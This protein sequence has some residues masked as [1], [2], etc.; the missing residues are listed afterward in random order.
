M[1]SAFRYFLGFC[2]LGTHPFG[3]RHVGSEHLDRTGHLADLVL[4]SDAGYGNRELAARGL[5]PARV[6]SPGRGLATE[7]MLELVN[8]GAF[9]YTIADRHV[10]ELWSGV[11]N[12]LRLEPKLELTTGDRIAWAVRRDN[13]ELKVVF[14]VT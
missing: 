2:L 6:E 9:P 4:A 12:G 11:L 5:A 14:H 7:D 13:P 8:S 10:A 3:L 1:R